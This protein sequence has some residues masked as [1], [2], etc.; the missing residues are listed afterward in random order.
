M[1]VPDTGQG[2]DYTANVRAEIA[3]RNLTHKA[4]AGMAGIPWSNFSRRMTG[5]VSW[6]TTDLERIAHALDIDV[7]ELYRRGPTT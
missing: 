2:P 6:S 4:A 1:T 7:A 3:R 5:A